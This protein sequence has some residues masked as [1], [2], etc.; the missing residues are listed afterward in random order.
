MQFVF[1]I[2]KIGLQLLG[3]DVTPR[4]AHII[5]HR[6]F[7]HLSQTRIVITRCENHS[8][9][10]KHCNSVLNVAAFHSQLS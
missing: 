2:L 1:T 8:N 9:N 7:I 5:P 10:A 6:C 4:N 3:V